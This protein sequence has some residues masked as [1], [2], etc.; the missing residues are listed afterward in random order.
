[1]RLF[2]GH[3][4]QPLGF[5]IGITLLN[6]FLSSFFIYYESNLVKKRLSY[7]ALKIAQ[8]VFNG[9]T[10]CD[11]FDQS[12]G[13]FLLIFNVRYQ[14]DVFDQCQRPFVIKSQETIKT[15]LSNIY[16]FLIYIYRFK[17]HIYVYIQLLS[18][19]SALRISQLCLSNM[20]YLNCV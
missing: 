13:Q 2:S 19:V 5:K 7:G 15:D 18:C 4:W 6:T 10:I 17:Q 3:L 1:M 14:N 11:V 8:R 16:I 12:Q 9:R 20:G